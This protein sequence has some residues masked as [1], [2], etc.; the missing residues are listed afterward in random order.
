MRPYAIVTG[1]FV[2]TG[3]MDRAN[4]GLADFLA[5]A[6]AP[7]HLIAHRVADDLAA[8]PNVTFHKVPKPFDR[9]ALGA[10]LLGGA[11]LALALS[12]AARRGTV[13]VNGGNCVVPGVNWVHYVHAAFEPHTAGGA[14]RSAI[15]RHRIAVMTERLALRTARV[16]ITNSERTRRDVIDRVGVAEDRAHTVYLGIDASSFALV[17]D[18]ERAEARRALGWGG[19]HPRVAFVGALGDRRKGFDVLYDAWRILCAKPSWDAD[20]VVI[21]AGAELSV[22]RERAERD[23]IHSRVSFL[24]FRRD[25]PTILAASDA[26]VAPSRYEPY[27]LGAHEALCRGLP[28]LVAASAGVAER[29]PPSLRDLLLHDVESAA[30]VAATLERWRA[31]APQMRADVVAFSDVLR[32]RSWDDMARQFVARALAT[33]GA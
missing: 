27:G 5:R 31:S 13:V 25:V 6:G 14:R 12:I 8:Y 21:G 2:R 23:R 30:Q 15:A 33:A 28:A 7:V 22:W 26:V 19:D 9:Y 10:P 29:Y 11:G 32:A 17:G 3:G 24:G 4:F 20:L 1:D 18:E 16:V